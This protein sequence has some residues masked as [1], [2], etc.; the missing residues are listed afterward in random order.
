M[1]SD[2]PV[3]SFLSG[4]IDS[5]IVTLIAS[6]I[7]PKLKSFTVGFELNGYSEVEHAKSTANF[8][9]IENIHKFISCEEFITELPKIIWHMDVPVADPAEIPL[10]FIAK[11]A[12]KHV[13]VILSGEGA[14]ELFGGYNIYNEP[15]SLRMFNHIPKFMKNFLRDFSH[16]LPEGTKGKSFLYRGCT[17]LEKRY[18]GNANIFKEPEKSILLNSYNEEFASEYFIN[19][20]YKK[21]EDL[22]CIGK[23]QYIDLCTWLKGDILVKSDRMTMANSLE[24]RVPFLDREVFKVASSLGYEDK[25]YNGTTKYLLREAF[26]SELPMDLINR[27]KLGYPVPIRVWLKNE[28]YPWA[29]SLIKESHTEKYINKDY[30]IKLLEEHRKGYLDNS[31]KIWTILIFMLWHKIFIEDSIS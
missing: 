31:R 3:A 4:G 21:V 7:N 6:K 12:S 8:I 19:S 1:L 10:Y 5:S 27:K 17:P 11:E 14:D 16:I 13:R 28:L 30:V 22:D 15:N 9:G 26:K 18:F 29:T 24:L 25:V 20:F 23:M 2:F